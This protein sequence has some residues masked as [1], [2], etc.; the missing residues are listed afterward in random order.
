MRTVI[1]YLLLIVFASTLLGCF[2][3][4]IP[5]KPPAPFDNHDQLERL[6]GQKAEEVIGEFGYP[7]QLLTDGARR[8]LM[9]WTTSSGANVLFMLWVPV[10]VTGD[11]E[12]TLHC[13]RFELDLDNRVKVYGIESG[14]WQKL[15]DTYDVSSRC[16][17]F[18]W[19]K[20]ELAGIKTS[21]DF[22]EEW[23]ELATETGHKQFEMYRAGIQSSPEY[24]LEM[25]CEAADYGHKKANRQLG[26]IH[27]L[28]QVPNLRYQGYVHK[29]DYVKAYVWYARSDM[30]EQQLQDFAN[31]RLNSGNYRKAQKAL[32]EWEPGQCMVELGLSEE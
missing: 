2:G 7:N 32:A 17:S 11:G 20:K 13:V 4:T 23:R 1:S 18:F 28:A 12:A 8:F 3:A 29:R 5:G 10:A 27:E 9:Y 15:F 26:I 21:T 31:A 6:I 19:S 25:L 14:G 24:A 22:G 16:Q 30:N